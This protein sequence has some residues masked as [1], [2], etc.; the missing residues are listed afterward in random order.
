[1]CRK[2]GKQIQSHFPDLIFNSLGVKKKTIGSI[3]EADYISH[4]HKKN[5]REI[6]LKT[7]LIHRCK[8]SLRR[9]A[10]LYKYQL[11]LSSNSLIVG[12]YTQNLQT[13]SILFEAPGSCPSKQIAFFNTDSLTIAFIPS[14]KRKRLYKSSTVSLGPTS[15]SRCRRIG[16]VS[17]PSSAQKMVNPAFLSP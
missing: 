9:Y 6:I 11:L 14:G 12:C 2:V 7:V 5:G 15:H 8:I 4:T 10:A 13:K 3:L 16:P 1:M 17:R